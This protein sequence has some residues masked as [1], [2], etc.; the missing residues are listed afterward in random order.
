MRGEVGGDPGPH[1]ERRVHLREV[2]PD[3]V[4]VL[5]DGGDGGEGVAQLRVGHPVRLR[6]SGATPPFSA[7]G[8]SSMSVGEP[9]REFR[10]LFCLSHAALPCVLCAKD[11]RPPI[12]VTCERQSL[13]RISVA[14]LSAIRAADWCTESRARCAYR[15]VDSI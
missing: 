5:G 15:E 9:R 13:P 14:M 4:A 3:H 2:E 8:I 12:Y 7:V 10:R 11:T 1:V 6:R